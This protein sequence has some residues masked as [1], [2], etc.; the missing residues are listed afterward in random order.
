MP[1]EVD[2]KTRLTLTPT[3]AKTC[4]IVPDLERLAFPVDC[5]TPLPSSGRRRLPVRSAVSLGS[6]AP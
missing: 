1:K 2:I 5:L 4:K 3:R 6:R